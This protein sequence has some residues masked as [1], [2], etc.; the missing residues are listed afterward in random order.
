[1]IQR[2]LAGFTVEFANAIRLRATYIGPALVALTVLVLTFQYPITRDAVSDF[3]FV[4]V[5]V[6]TAVDFVG[7]FVLLIYCSAQ[8]SV[9]VGSGLIRTILLRPLRRREYFLSKL[10]MG[11][12]YAGILMVIAVV[13]ALIIVLITGELSGIYYGDTV[14]YSSAEMRNALF[15]ALALNLLPLFA[16]VAFALF[17]STLSRSRTVAVGLALSVWVCLDLIKHP[18]GIERYFFSTYLE[19]SWDVFLDQCN[20]LPSD[21]LAVAPWAAGVSAVWIV[22]LSAAALLVL[23]RRDFT[24]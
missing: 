24:Q 5:A 3:G 14:V 16:T 21:W 10:L 6:P 1:M 11:W 4:A 19:H 2:I 13:L 20:A 12:T 9:D 18:L 7:I 15:A 17:M 8:I 23:S 22:F